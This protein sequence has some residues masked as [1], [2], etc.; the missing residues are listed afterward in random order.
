MVVKGSMVGR[1][2]LVLILVVGTM[3]RVASASRDPLVAIERDEF[4]P[5]AMTITK[6]HLPLRAAQHGILPGYIIRAGGLAFGNSI[7]GLRLISVIAGVATIL[8]LYVVGARWWGQSGGLIAAALLAVERYHINVSARAIDLPFELFFLA[9]AIYTFSRFLYAIKQ[10]AA[11]VEAGRWLYGAAS[12]CALG[13]LCKELTI[14]MAPVLLLTLLLVRQSA[15]LRRRET[16]RNEFDEFPFINPWLASL[17]WVGV[18]LTFV[19]RGKDELAIM[20]LT[21]FTVPLL[22]FVSM[23]LGPPLGPLPTDDVMLWHWADRTMLPALLLTGRAVSL[24]ARER[25]W[26]KRLS[27]AR[28]PR[29]STLAADR[30]PGSSSK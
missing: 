4:I 24:V 16:Y 3:L 27:T 22:V 26:K 30:R 8:L 12:A 25:T 23:R 18:A 21:M 13:F 9:I 17:L 28:V 2:L 10:K 7:L 5:I 11:P 6:E 20:L 29:V 14:L 19:R 1:L 15:W